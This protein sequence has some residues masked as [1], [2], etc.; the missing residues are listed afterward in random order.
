MDGAF[1]YER[2]EESPAICQ[3]GVSPALEPRPR[4]TILLWCIGSVFGA[5]ML[6]LLIGMWVAELSIHRSMDGP[7]TPPA[8]SSP[9]TLAATRSFPASSH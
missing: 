2:D 9:I 1:A 5:G 7:T 8:D 4:E 6:A 3:D